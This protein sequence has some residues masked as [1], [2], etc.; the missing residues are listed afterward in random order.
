MARSV[1]ILVFPGVQA[2]DVTGPMDV[3][4]EANRFLPVEDHYRLEVIGLQAGAQVCS[5]GL[6]LQARRSFEEAVEAF[7]LLLVAGGPQVPGSDFGPAFDAWLR[8]AC[9]RAAGFGSICNGAF[10]L[11]RA[12]LLEG[13]TVTTHWS[14][15]PALATLYP[16]TRVEVDRLYVE[17][18]RLFTSAGVTAGIDLSLYLL[19]KDRGAEVALNVAKRLVVFTQRAG[20]QSQ[21]SPFLLPQ[22]TATSVVAQVQQYVLDHLQDNLSI[23]ELARAAHMSPRN[24]SRVF[25]REAGITPAEFVERAR[26]DAARAL[27]ERS[28][29]PLKTLAYRCGFRGAQHLLRVFKRRLGLTPQQFRANFAPPSW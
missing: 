8:G 19:A 4:C 13:R 20:G 9:A 29:A 6:V 14:D 1:A 26:V 22:A 18:D 10:I 12:G 24:F 27:L 15:A 3:F 2:L 21:F 7:D 28:S 5:N 11:A 25:V 17:D 16:S 23:G